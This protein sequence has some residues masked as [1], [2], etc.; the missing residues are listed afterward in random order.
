MAKTE[1]S[2]PT[3]IWTPEDSSFSYG[4]AIEQARL[5]MNSKNPDQLIHEL[6]R[7]VK[8]SD[9]GIVYATLKGNKPEEYSETDAMVT[10]SPFANTATANMLVRAEFIRTVAEKSG[11]TDAHGKLKPV[12]MLAAP[13]IYGSRLRLNHA[14]KN[15][16]RSGDLGPA[17]R[18][19][20]DS[21]SALD[22]GRVA[23]LGFSQG[24]DLALSAIQKAESSNL[25]A[26]TLSIGEPPDVKE[27]RAYELALDFLASN[28]QLQKS[29]SLGELTAQGQAVGRQ[30]FSL[31][32]NR[33]LVRFGGT[34]LTPSNLMLWSGMSKNSFEKNMQAA[35]Q[36][37]KIDKII[38]GYGSKGKVTPAETIE[39]ILS[40]LHEQVD[41]SR[42]ISIK[43]EGKDHS[44]GDQLPLLAKL[45]MKALV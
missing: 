16:I 11:V 41:D 20:L 38:V 17:A 8:R 3:E 23:L 21:V 30:A 12:I 43:V 24:A 5:E 31:N 28:G 10:F 25:D 36:A 26:R 7:Q 37:G 19:F 1:T 15:Q 42:L 39:P 35:L 22:F 40:R 6:K 2:T 32:R 14:E 33:D 45:Y 44:W 9:N 13:G 27:R 34:A 29:I 4:E 18:E